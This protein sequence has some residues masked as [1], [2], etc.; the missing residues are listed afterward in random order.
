MT[1]KERRSLCADGAFIQ[2]D[3]LGRMRTH[4]AI[5]PHSEHG[6]TMPPGPI[7]DLGPT[8]W[9]TFCLQAGRIDR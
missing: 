4:S 8:I 3:A 5:T 1:H 7:L 6:H 9:K 2:C